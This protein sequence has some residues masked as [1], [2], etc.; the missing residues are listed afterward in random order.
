MSGKVYMV[1]RETRDLIVAFNK[2]SVGRAVIPPAVDDGGPL[3]GIELGDEVIAQLKHLDPD[4][5]A[6]IAKLVWGSSKLV[7]Q[8]RAAAATEGPKP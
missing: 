8:I 2:R 1:R 3:V 6:A 5:D 4:L 7:D